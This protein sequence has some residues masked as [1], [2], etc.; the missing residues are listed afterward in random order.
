MFEDEGWES[1]GPPALMRHTSRLRWGTK[2]LLESTL[3]NTT[4]AGEASLWGREQ[5]A[6]STK[7]EIGRE[8]ND[9]IPGQALFVNARARPGKTLLS[10]TARK[11]QFACYS[12]LSLVAG[13]FNASR[14]E[15]GILT[16]RRGAS[17]TKGVERMAAPPGMLFSGFWSLVENNGIAVAEQAETFED[18]LAVPSEVEVKGPRSN[19]RIHG[20]AEVEKHV[21]LDGRIGPI[22]V[23][24]GA[25]VES[26]SRLMGPCY[27]GPKVK[28]YSALIGGG[29]SVFG[30]CKIGGQV[31]DSIISPFTNKAH[32]GYVG[33]AY[34]GE[35]VNLGA[36]STFS[37]LKNTYGNVRVDTGKERVDSGMLKLGPALGDMTKVS[38]GALVF[39]GKTVGT[40]SQV[41]GLAR[42]NVPSFTF[43]DGDAG[44]LVELYLESVLETQR[45]MMERRG[46]ALTRKQEKL[47]RLS[48]RGTSKERRA[49]RVKKGSIR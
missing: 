10:L 26:F 22:V 46:L 30:G 39:A 45:R 3:E 40:G 24:R 47:V 23:D 42:E 33:D 5:L 27:V 18:P 8:Y 28:L 31:E 49:A 21:T 7:E 2:T 13:R 43:Y 12:G 11:A 16:A 20:D 19:L 44:K 32:H 36:G 34:V 48:F 15:P 38:I 6:E 17:A 29:T 41:T 14:L 37:N 25:S 4:E 35:W 1:F 9:D